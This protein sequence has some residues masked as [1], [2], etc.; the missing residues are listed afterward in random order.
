MLWQALS[1]KQCGWM[2]AETYCKIHIRVN[3]CGDAAGCTQF[4]PYKD[5][6]QVEFQ[7]TQPNTVFCPMVPLKETIEMGIS[8]VIS[9]AS[10]S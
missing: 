1:D 10:P 5:V 7:S 3:Y 6:I 4:L 8:P 9:P 2:R